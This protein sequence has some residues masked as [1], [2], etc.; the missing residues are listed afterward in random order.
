MQKNSNQSQNP[1]QNLTCHT[2]ALGFLRPALLHPKINVD[3]SRGMELL[4]K[5]KSKSLPNV[6]F[7]GEDAGATNQGPTSHKL[8]IG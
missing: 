2:W 7:G 1:S 6:G 3:V 5:R 8:S 4:G